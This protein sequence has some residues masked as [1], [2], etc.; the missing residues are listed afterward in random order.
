[1]VKT[2]TNNDKKIRVM[3]QALFQDK[4]QMRELFPGSLCLR[5]KRETVNTQLH[6]KN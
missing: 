1:M 6:R 2:T 5:K 4:Q 3:C